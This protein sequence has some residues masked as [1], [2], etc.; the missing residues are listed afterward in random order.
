METIKHL[1]DKHKGEDIYV[2]ASGKSLDFVDESFFDNKILV[3]VN[4]AY[5]KIWCDYL[6]RKETKFI[7]DS[8]AT[9][10]IV[11][12]S[13]YDSGN[14]DT[15]NSKLNT[16]KVKHDNLYYFEHLDNRHNQIDTSVFGTDKIVVSFSTITSAIH[17]AAYMGAAN[18]I[19]VGHDCGV[20]DG[21][22][23]FKGYYNSIKDTPWQDWRQYKSWLK[24]IESQTIIVKNEVKKHYNSNVVSL[25]PF[26]SLNLENHIYQ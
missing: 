24:I 17:I 22:M 18:I 19:L 3:G 10:S 5:K 25:N 1:K 6:V 15:G 16:N 23:T 12:V 2:I 21:E 26:V 4:Q 8:L 13:E 9:D 20:I 11:I 7:K 14:L